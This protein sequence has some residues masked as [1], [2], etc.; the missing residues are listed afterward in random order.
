MKDRFLK[1]LKIFLMILGAIFLIQLLLLVGAIAGIVGFAKA[2]FNFLDLDIDENKNLKPVMP[3]IEYVENYRKENGIYPSNIKDV[4]MKKNPNL[5]Y[6]YETSN[7][8]NCYTITIKSKN[9]KM[10]KKYQNCAVDDENSTSKSR[11]YIEYF[12]ESK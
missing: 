3:I 5:Y 6:N 11:S 4:K 7:N 8:D 2:D 9:D 12:D 10:I 1:V